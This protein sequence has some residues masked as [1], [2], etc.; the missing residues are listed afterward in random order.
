LLEITQIIANFV[1]QLHEHIQLKNEQFAKQC[2]DLDEIKYFGSEEERTIKRN[3]E[4]TTEVFAKAANKF[5]GIE[6]DFQ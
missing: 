4:I 5:V 1:L 3:L 6:R 2:D